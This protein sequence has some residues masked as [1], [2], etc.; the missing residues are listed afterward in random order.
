MMGY[1]GAVF[2]SFFGNGGGMLLGFGILLVWMAM[3]LWLAVRRFN[4]KD[5]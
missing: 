3:P 1:T 4:H 5:L 2:K